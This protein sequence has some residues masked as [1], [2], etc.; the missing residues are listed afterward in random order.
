M[1][2]HFSSIG[3]SQL[4]SEPAC[5][6]AILTVIH[7]LSCVVRRLG[8]EQGDKKQ[9]TATVAFTVLAIQRAVPKISLN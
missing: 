4:A 1:G 3:L 8:S 9:Q 2:S 6:V 5:C 7:K